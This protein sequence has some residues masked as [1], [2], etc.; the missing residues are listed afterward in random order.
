MAITTANTILSYSA[1]KDGTYAKLVDII[2]YP[3]MGS[4]PSKLDT[5]TLSNLKRKTN[6]FGLEDAVDLSFEALYDSTSLTTINALTGV[7]WF[8]LEFG[9]DGEDGG[10]T[11]S[12]EAS[13][14]VTGGGVDEVRKMM[15]SIST[16]TEI[17]E[18]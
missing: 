17:E 9:D 5:T 11:W 15:V 16:E 4:A 1:T 3:D 2:A 12:G 13:A 8:T 10:Y 18:L 14:Y 7:Q 6:V